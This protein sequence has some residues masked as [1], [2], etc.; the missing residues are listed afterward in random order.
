MAESVLPS[1]ADGFAK[2]FGAQIIIVAVSPNRSNSEITMQSWVFFFLTRKIGR[3]DLYWYSVQSDC[4]KGRVKTLL[5][6]IDENG[7]KKV[8]EMVI[9]YGKAFFCKS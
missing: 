1:F 4:S 6:Q 3:T 2:W 7:W 9:R 5:P 8:Q